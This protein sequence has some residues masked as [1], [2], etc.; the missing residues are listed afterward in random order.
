MVHKHRGYFASTVTEAGSAETAKCFCTAYKK[1]GY[2][3]RWH[4][5]ETGFEI[6]SGPVKQVVGLRQPNREGYHSAEGN[7][8]LAPLYI[9]IVRRFNTVAT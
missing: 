5:S 6:H 3:R 8:T 7:V 9:T 4:L 1:R 2:Y